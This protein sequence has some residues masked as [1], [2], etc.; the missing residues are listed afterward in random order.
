MP[1]A[2][3]AAFLGGTI[4]R[5]WLSSDRETLTIRTTERGP[6]PRAVGHSDANI[7]I[8]AGAVDGSEYL[9]GSAAG[10]IG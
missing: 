1:S 4:S 6:T 2:L 5:Q 10:P 3:C 9:R 8:A 7:A